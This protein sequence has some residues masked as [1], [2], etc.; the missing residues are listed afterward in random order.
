MAGMVMDM[1]W[2]RMMKGART[3]VD[4]CASVKPDEQVLIITDTHA[5]AGGPMKAAIHYDLVIWRPT[6]ELDGKMVVD[7]GDINLDA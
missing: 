4:D 5:R 7:N 3:L 1:E 2:T 6:I